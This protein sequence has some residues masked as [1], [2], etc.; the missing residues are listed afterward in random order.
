MGIGGQLG[1]RWVVRQRAPPAGWVAMT[2]TLQ[3]RSVLITGAAGGLG[4]TIANAM[5][6]LGA[7][8]FLVDI[9]ASA[10]L[11]VRDRLA[12]HA[13]VADITDAD[14]PAQDRGALPDHR[15]PAGCPDQQRGH[16][17]GQ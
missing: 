4:S 14:A 9:D 2:A 5:S 16:R 3:G 8:L 10:L 1:Q 7:S 12:C 15:A 6:E 13:L 17:E 11:G